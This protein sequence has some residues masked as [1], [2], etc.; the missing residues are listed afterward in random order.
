MIGFGPTIWSRR[1]GETEYGLKAI[2]LG[3]YISMIGMFPPA[4]G[5]KV[6]ADSTRVLPRPRAGRTRLEHGVDHARRRGSRLLPASGLEAHHHHVRRAVH[7]PAARGRAVR[8]AAHGVR[9]NR[10][11]STT[12]GTVSACA[13]PATSERQTC[14]PGDPAAP[15]A[16]AGIEPGDRIVS[17]AGEPI[18]DLGRVDRDHP[19]PPRR[20]DRASWSCATATR[21]R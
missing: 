8:G 16:A 4:K 17:V 2:P 19:R 18:D 20:G 9:R 12:V 1:Q 3:G 15:G 7:E 13:L 14:E 10:R 6:H 11:P 21:S 5:A